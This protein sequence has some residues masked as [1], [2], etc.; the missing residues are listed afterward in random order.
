MEFKLKTFNY[1]IKYNKVLDFNN[2]K[3]QYRI[4]IFKKINYSKF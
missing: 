2:K 4:K 3:M 1:K